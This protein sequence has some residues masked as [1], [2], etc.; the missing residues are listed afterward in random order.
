[1]RSTL[2][3]LGTATAVLCSAAPASAMVDRH[4]DAVSELASFCQPHRADEVSVIVWNAYVAAGYT[5]VPDGTP[6]GD[7]TALIHPSCY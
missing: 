5:A 3:L 6:S 4:G 2:L 1:M 7:V